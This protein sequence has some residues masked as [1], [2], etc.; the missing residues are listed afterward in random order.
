VISEALG[1]DRTQ[2]QNFRCLE[3]NKINKLL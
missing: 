1:H 2:S 3:K